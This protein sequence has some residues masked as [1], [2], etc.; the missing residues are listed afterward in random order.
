MYSI[1]IFGSDITISI[2]LF[3]FYSY[4]LFCSYKNVIIFKW[5]Y[6][7]NFTTISRDRF[8]NAQ[9]YIRIILYNFYPRVLI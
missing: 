7:E 1:I 6:E 9:I 4:I 5:Q 3:K 2:N 8:G